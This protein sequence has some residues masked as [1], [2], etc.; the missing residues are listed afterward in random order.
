[1]EEDLLF[2]GT[3]D[4]IGLS[5]HKTGKWFKIPRERATYVHP[6]IASRNYRYV[7]G[8]ETPTLDGRITG[9]VV[10]DKELQ[11]LADIIPVPPGTENVYCVFDTSK[12]YLA[13]LDSGWQWIMMFDL[14]AL[15]EREAAAG[16]GAPPAPALE[17]PKK[18]GVVDK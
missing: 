10:V 4:G 5:D 12:Q 6:F 13:L 18:D 14:Q 9:V 1:M 3:P 2:G 8:T 16:K 7:F 17:P 15:A 11:K